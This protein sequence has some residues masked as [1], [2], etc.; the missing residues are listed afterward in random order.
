MAVR[1]SKSSTPDPVVWFGERRREPLPQPTGTYFDAFSVDSSPSTTR[2]FTSPPLVTRI[3]STL[4]VREQ[5]MWIVV[6]GI[7]NECDWLQAGQSNRIS[8]FGHPSSVAVEFASNYIT[9]RETLV[10]SRPR[11]LK[12]AAR[13]VR[14]EQTKPYRKIIVTTRNSGIRMHTL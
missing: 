5:V 13:G 9:L 10:V 8:I 1:V 3:S 2:D 7:S 11:K 12:R 6:S 14:P 4:C